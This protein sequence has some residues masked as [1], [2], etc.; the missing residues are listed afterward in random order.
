[1]KRF[2]A[3]ICSIIL[4]LALTVLILIMSLEGFISKKNIETIIG[5]VDFA[6][7]T[8]N[9]FQDNKEIYNTL[10][11][12]GISK[13][14]VDETINS[15]IIKDT[16]AD[17]INN[18]LDYYVRGNE[19]AKLLTDE[20]LEALLKDAIQTFS[21]LAEIKVTEK[22]EQQIYDFVKPEL[23]KIQEELPAMKDLKTENPEVTRVL[24][25][26]KII[27]STKV[28]LVLILLSALAFIGIFFL[29][30]KEKSYLLWYGVNAIVVSI[31]LFLVFGMLQL[32]MK[33][34]ITGDDVE[35][36]TKI[37]NPFISKGFIYA[38][39][40]IVIGILLIITHCFLNKEKKPLD[41][42]AA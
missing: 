11:Q 30:K 12:W 38:T 4:I 35:Q 24:E 37:L 9:A 23:N 20:Q 10:E 13:E 36:L 21:Q 27:F 6:T 3:T 17:I 42:T 29:R 16:T 19:E 33:I 15:Q 7:V 34:G 41:T 5:D 25:I 14:Q 18:A 2:G 40:V 28:K 8:D 26:T 32:L 31:L 22:M 39:I 1:M